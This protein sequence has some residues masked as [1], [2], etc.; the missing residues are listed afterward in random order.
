MGKGQR[1]RERERITSR[2]HTVSTESHVWL[3]LMT[4]EIMTWGK[5]RVGCLTN[6]TAQ[7]SLSTNISILNICIYQI[8]YE[9]LLMS[10]TLI[11][12]YID[13]SVWYRS[14][15]ICKFLL[16][17]WETWFP[18]STI[19]LFDCSIPVCMYRGISTVNLCLGGKQIYQLEYTAYVQL[20]LLLVLPDLI[21]FQSYL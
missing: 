1:E 9:F 18:P 3:N 13:H 5:P 11:H 20:L 2:V 16:Q 8:K 17:Q 4:S 7:V 21:H 14:L 6:W 15:L 10:P 19:H 12:Y